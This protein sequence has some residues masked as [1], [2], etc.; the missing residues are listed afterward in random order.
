MTNGSG[1]KQIKIKNL[2]LNLILCLPKGDKISNCR[3]W[4]NKHLQNRKRRLV[5]QWQKRSD[6]A[7]LNIFIQF[8]LN[9]IKTN[10]SRPF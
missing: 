2:K 1:S 7:I 6:N 5:K 8:L 10:Q 4:G 3:K 9:Q